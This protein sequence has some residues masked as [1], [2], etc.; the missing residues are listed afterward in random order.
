[1]SNIKNAFTLLNNPSL[2]SS[3]LGGSSVHG[4]CVQRASLPDF[5]AATPRVLCGQDL[6]AIKKIESSIAK[7]GL[8]T[9]LKVI[10]FDGKL[11]V[12]DGR[13]RLA[14]L[15]RMAFHGTLPSALKHIPYVLT[16]AAA[17][18][19]S[20]ALST[21]NITPIR[22]VNKTVISRPAHPISGLNLGF[23]FAA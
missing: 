16:A 12:I 14:A 18:P 11:V 6:Y 19:K 8:I 2:N 15:R 5:R 3:K 10:R 13:K 4:S 9:A 7:H 20:S 23:N 1:M 21:V 22:P 17:E